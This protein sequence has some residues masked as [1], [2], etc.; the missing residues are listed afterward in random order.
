MKSRGRKTLIN[1]LLTFNTNEGKR[2]FV[3]KVFEIGDVVIFSAVTDG[4]LKRE[5]FEGTIINRKF[6]MYTIKVERY[7][8]F[9]EEPNCFPNVF[10]AD[11]LEFVQDTNVPASRIQA[12]VRS[13][14]CRKY[15]RGCGKKIPYGSERQRVPEIGWSGTCGRF[16]QSYGIT[17]W[18][19]K[20]SAR[21]G[22]LHGQ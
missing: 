1:S 10:P 18:C 5:S 22:L 11:I 7:S 19:Q 9:G 6:G 17:D 15:L 16:N 13:F 3:L 2:E 12:F 4:S 8:S 21:L 14:I 20:C